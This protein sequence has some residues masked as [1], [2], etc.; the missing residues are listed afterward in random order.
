MTGGYE[1][2]SKGFLRVLS[3]ALVL[4]VDVSFVSAGPMGPLLAKDANYFVM[5]EVHASA[6]GNVAVLLGADP[7]SPLPWSSTV[8]DT[9]WTYQLLSAP[10]RDGRLS[11]G[12][13]G[14]FDPAQDVIS[15]H[16]E[17]TFVKNQG[18]VTWTE[19][20]TY[21]DAT[22][23]GYFRKLFNQVARLILPV[24]PAIVSYAVNGA[25]DGV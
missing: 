2:M 25:Q 15:W 5:Q 9:G 4:L 20:V 23:D 13:A 14:T 10:Y 12:Y 7:T 17:G 21:E 18:S 16:G 22:V 19:T 1:D 8:S 11:M 6:L 24:V 3:L